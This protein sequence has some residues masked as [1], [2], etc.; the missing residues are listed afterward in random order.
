MKPILR[1]DIDTKEIIDLYFN[2]KLSLNEISKKLNCSECLI[3]GRIMREGYKSRSWSEAKIIKPTRY[4][5]NKKCPEYMIQKN[6]E[7][8]IKW[9]KENRNRVI[10]RPDTHGKN[11]PFYGKHHTEATV[12]VIR[13]ARAKQNFS[14]YDSSIE[15]KIQGFLRTLG[16]EHFTHFCI[17]DIE[18]SYSCDIFVP[19]MKLV[20]E[21]DG[22]YFHGNPLLFPNYKLNKKQKEQRERDKIRNKELIEKGYKVL[23][24]WENEIRGLSM[25]EFNV[26]INKT[27]QEEVQAP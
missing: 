24:L 5:L 14:F 19:S 12:K 7:A 3:R 25:E 9:W 21:A 22:D 23:R 6:S 27:V 2:K 16:I 15:L 18:H 1:K 8:K 10:L 11:N 20:I 13:D 4:W 26:M 17:N